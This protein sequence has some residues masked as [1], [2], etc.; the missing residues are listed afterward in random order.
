MACS[1]AAGTRWTTKRLKGLEPST[2]CMASRRSSQLSY[3]RARA[4]SI[5]ANRRE[6]SRSGRR[7]SGW[8]ACT[9]AAVRGW[10][11]QT[12]ATAREKDR[13][14]LGPPCAPAGLVPGTV[15]GVV[16]GTNSRRGAWH[17]FGAWCLAPIVVA[18]AGV[19]VA[20]GRCGVALLALLHVEIEQES[21][22]TGDVFLLLVGD[23]LHH[24]LRSLVGQ[25]VGLRLVAV[26]RPQ[27]LGQVVP[28]RLQVGGQLCQSH[29]RILTGCRSGPAAAARSSRR[30]PTSTP[31][32]CRARPGPPR[33]GH[34]RCTSCRRTAAGS[35]RRSCRR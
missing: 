26:D 35:R 22:Q 29:V 11:A 4:P 10:P 17:R 23:P 7:L 13:R 8:C 33:D 2:F 14:R 25:R 15:L 16:P 20:S 27:L 30:R 32:R 6:L 9:P 21:V 19:R 34:S 28:Q 24:L 12:A 1:A 3:S 18:R 31:C 5:P